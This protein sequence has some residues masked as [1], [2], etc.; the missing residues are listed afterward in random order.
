MLN[1]VEQFLDTAEAGGN[2]RVLR[3]VV[4]LSA[5]S[6]EV[7]G[8][9]FLN[10]S[11]NN[12]LGLSDHPLLKEESIAW[13]EKYG[14]GAA[15]S[16]LV[17]GTI[18]VYIQ[19]ED[20]I[21]SWKGTEAALIIGSGYMANTGVIPALTDRK[22]VIFADKINHASLNAGCQLSGSKFIRY[23]HNDMVHLE[24]LLE[25]YSD[26]EQK[27]I[28]VDT[29]F[30]MDGDIAPLE[31][32]EHLAEKHK[33]MLYLDDA[34]GTGVYGDSGEGLVGG[35]KADILMGTFSKAMGSYGAYIACSRRMKEYLVNRCGSFIYTTALPPGVCG[36]ISAAVKLVQ[37]DE[38]SQIRS[39]YHK[40][41][42]YV[43]AEL[44][45]MGFD[46]GD[47]QT[48]IIPVILGDSEKVLDAAEFLKSRGIFVVG[49]RPPTVPKGTA[50]LRFTV[51]AAHTEADVELLLAAM[52]ELKEF[53]ASYDR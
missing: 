47:T 37:T 53:F 12:Y 18:D 21:A 17:S 7:D 36:S 8:H 32:I 50:R 20:E 6:C 19:L 35:H 1:F 41:V 22:S 4:P 25:K 27:L 30:S 5:R 14:V 33:A 42:S 44:Q 40:R 39:E 38:Y 10:F 26:I 43:T 34:H 45:K 3:G 29:V 11:A 28:V 24:S 51:N 48:G 52:R 13:T 15:A 46:T 16:R 23:R 31:Q 49:I 9:E 2:K